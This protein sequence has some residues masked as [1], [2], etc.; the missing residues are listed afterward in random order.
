M[1]ATVT[2]DSSVRGEVTVVTPGVRSPISLHSHAFAQRKAPS[3]SVYEFTGKKTLESTNEHMI[4][5]M[6]RQDSMKA[7]YLFI[8]L[9]TFSPPGTHLRRCQA[10]KMELLK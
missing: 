5:V 2:H 6:Q 10:K 1:H 8:F 9:R 4:K 3:I 7:F